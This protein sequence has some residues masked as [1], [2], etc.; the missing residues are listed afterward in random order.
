MSEQI[1]QAKR[2]V[3]HNYALSFDLGNNR[4]IQV[5]GNFYID[6]SILDMNVKLDQIWIVLERL[7][8]KV[9][10]E[11]LALDLKQ[12][13]TMVRQTEELLVRAEATSDMRKKAGK[14]MTT[15]QDA[16]LANLHTNLIK[17]RQ[18]IRDIEGML[19][20]KRAQAA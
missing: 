2:I 6:D 13:Q 3:G 7:R 16:D 10:V 19:V 14:L 8:A 11:A 15:Q 9:Q 20:E 5:N 12:A 1:D 4:S 17:Q 18:D